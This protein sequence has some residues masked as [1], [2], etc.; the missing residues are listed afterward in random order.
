YQVTLVL[1]AIACILHTKEPERQE[2]VLLTPK[3][4]ESIRLSLPYISVVM[5]IVFILVEYVFAPI[6][7]IGLMITFSFV[8]IRH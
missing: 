4:G 1:V 8:L 3:L 6:V 5:L 7:V 2:Q